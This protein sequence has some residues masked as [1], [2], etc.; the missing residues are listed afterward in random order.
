MSFLL[1]GATLSQSTIYVQSKRIHASLMRPY[2]PAVLFF[3]YNLFLPTI[4]PQLRER[5]DRMDELCFLCARKSLST[6]VASGASIEK[7]IHTSDIVM[8]EDIVV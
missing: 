4:K 2:L 7:L 1:N 8:P 5:L 3:C 6:E